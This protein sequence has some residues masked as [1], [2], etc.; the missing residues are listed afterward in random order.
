MSKIHH[1]ITSPFAPAAALAVSALALSGGTVLA[2]DG[3]A[4][5]RASRTTLEEIVVEAQRRTESQ[6][7]VP[8]SVTAVTGKALERRFAQDLR[9]LSA[10]SPNVQLEPVGI[11]QNAASFFI[12]G[13]GSADIE[14]AAD[15]GIA[16]FIDGVYQARTSTG[17]QDF[18]DVE[19][20]EIMRG[21]QGT[22]FGRNTIAGAVLM[23]HRKPEMDVFGI[24]GSVLAG[25]YGRLD[26][27]AKIN[28]PIIEDKVAFRLAFKSTNFD[29]YFKNTAKGDE[30]L[31]ANDRITIMPTL[32]FTP[33]DNL[34]IVIR[35]EFGRTRDDTYPAVNHTV[36]RDDPAN[37]F[38][39][40]PLDNDL[41]PLFATLIGG[42]A[43]AAANCGKPPSKEDFNTI[44][45]AEN[46][47]QANA[48]IWG[49]TGEVNYDVPD[50]GTFTYVGNYRE[51][52]ESI[53]FN[54]DV[55]PFDLFSGIRDQKHYQT[56]HELRF[57][58]DL[59]DKFDFVLG[60]YFFKQ[61]Y[62]MV[63]DSYGLLVTP[64]V[65]NGALPGDITTASDAIGANGGITGVSRQ[66]HDSWAVFGGLNYHLGE[67][68]TVLA[69]ARYTYEK[70]KFD[71]CGVGFADPI[72]ETC[73]VTNLNVVTGTLLANSFWA[74]A[75]SGLPPLNSLIQ[76]EENWNKVTP[77]A[78]IEFQINDDV[79]TFFTWT[80][81]FRSGGFPG[82]A[83]TVSS[84][85]PFGP[86]SADNFEI[87]IKSE[88]FDNRL[89]FNINAFWTE[90]DDLQRAFIRFAPGAAGQE[91][92]TDNAASVRT[93]GI[94]VEFQA[95]PTEGLTLN[96]S[97]GW[98]HS[99]QTDFCADLN[100]AEVDPSGDPTIIPTPL[101]GLEACGETVEVRDVLGNFVGWVVPTQNADFIPL[102]R[103]P[104]WQLAFGFAYEVPVGDA[105][106]LTFAADW[107]YSTKMNVAGGGTRPFDEEGVTQFNGDFLP[108]KRAA[109]HIINMNVT[110]EEID[111][112]Y[113]VSFFVKN[114]TNEVYIQSITTVAELFNF[115]VPNEP[116]HWGVEVSFDL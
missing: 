18:L 64:G 102:F 106:F 9:D 20:V 115:R 44:H 24:G 93:Q 37:L 77:R 66:S 54:I 75:P 87:G 91:T 4:D 110:W 74:L 3:G 88:W 60:A 80:R 69:G 67:R 38:T 56:S 63:Q 71:H 10:M 23:R 112:R 1:H 109:A 19:A 83:V 85:K 90:L 76:L 52:D 34:D 70:K 53:I 15:P 62:R 58:S 97:I 96:G 12:R 68:I 48:D 100:G 73:E 51:V 49:I 104:K 86:E 50:V 59:S 84:A 11:F 17:L 32:R 89:R 92:V 35:G 27:K 105:G 5:A 95:V 21:P 26:I 31:G 33:S 22:L 107:N 46:G 2:Q 99:K 114:V 39:G 41:A 36:C 30:D 14:S 61:R 111:N 13:Q 43:F 40:G 81:G 55:M 98:L 79:M 72:L 6:Q 101:F 25:E 78:G 42:P 116:R 16:I 94:E 57:A 65:F 29:G 28:I 45:S 113:R 47:D 8:V 7:T 108:M 82:R 103:S